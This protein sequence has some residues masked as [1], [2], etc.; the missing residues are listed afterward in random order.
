MPPVAK[1][2]FGSKSL[3]FEPDLEGGV[4]VGEEVDEGACV[5]VLVVGEAGLLGGGAM[6]LA[7]PETEAG[8]ST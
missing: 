1:M 5:D 6:A 2:T 8:S 3:V 4:E 7:G